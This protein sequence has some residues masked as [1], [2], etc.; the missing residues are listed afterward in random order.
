MSTK[1]RE[2]FTIFYSVEAYSQIVKI[3]RHFAASFSIVSCELSPILSLLLTRAGS[4]SFTVLST[5]TPP[6]I[7]RQTE[8]QH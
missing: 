1:F 7:L 6:T 3:S 8:R 2:I 5:S 4:T